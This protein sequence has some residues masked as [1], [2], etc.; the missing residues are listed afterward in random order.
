MKYR[1]PLFRTDGSPKDFKKM[2]DTIM[3]KREDIHFETAALDCKRHT[4]DP[5]MNLYLALPGVGVKKAK[6]LMEIYETGFASFVMDT[7]KHKGVNL[8]DLKGFGPKRS[9]TIFEALQ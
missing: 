3:E 4:K 6:T 7:W 2:L 8:K 5:K 1:I 9:Q